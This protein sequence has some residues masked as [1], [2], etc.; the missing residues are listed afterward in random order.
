MRSQGGGSV[1]S[2]EIP[3]IAENDLPRLSFP[4]RTCTLPGLQARLVSSRKPSQGVCH[5]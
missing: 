3:E 1:S 4:G 2:D 5:E